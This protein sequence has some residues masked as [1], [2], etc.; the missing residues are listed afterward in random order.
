[1]RA[2]SRPEQIGSV[3]NKALR[4]SGF[5]TKLR[6]KR[7]VLNWESV[8]GPRISSQAKAFKVEDSKLFVRVKSAVW[9]NEL[10]FQKKDIKDKLNQSVGGKVIKDIIFVNQ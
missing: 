4:K 10:F 6:E 3:L 8:V 1:M 7:V 5:Q 2:S 9:K